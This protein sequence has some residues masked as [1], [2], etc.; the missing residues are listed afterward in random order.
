MSAV[1]RGTTE[2]LSTLEP[3][4]TQKLQQGLQPIPDSELPTPENIER[5]ERR[6]PR[7]QW[8]RGT[9]RRQ[10]LHFQVEAIFFS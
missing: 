3:T 2:P 5:A 10:G 7:T 9:F 8:V 6:Q 4:P 1:K